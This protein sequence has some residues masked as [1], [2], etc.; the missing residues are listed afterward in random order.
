M[1]RKFQGMQISIIS[2]IKYGNIWI[3]KQKSQFL[4]EKG[5]G[6]K[7]AQNR[8][9]RDW[10]MQMVSVILTQKNKVMK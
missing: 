5:A 9:D 6:R 8:S 10:R 2:R 4:P 1:T 3:C 7:A